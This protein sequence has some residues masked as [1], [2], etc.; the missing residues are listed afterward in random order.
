ML[1][2]V[3]CAENTT[4]QHL[5]LGIFVASMTALVVCG[6]IVT[7][8]P[9]KNPRTLR[10]AVL[11]EHQ[12]GCFALEEERGG[13]WTGSGVPVIKEARPSLWPFTYARWGAVPAQERRI[14]PL[15]AKAVQEFSGAAVVVVTSEGLIRVD[16]RESRSASSDCERDSNECEDFFHGRILSKR[17]F[18]L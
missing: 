6:C 9:K 13:Q 10:P 7:R 17:Q 4:M 14:C 2:V 5:Y 12:P 3:S 8:K 16:D 18:E 1:A 15:V 11:D